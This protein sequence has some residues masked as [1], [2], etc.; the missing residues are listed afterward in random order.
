MKEFRIGHFLGLQLSVKPSAVVGTVLLLTLLVAVAYAILDQL[1]ATAVLGGATCVAVHWISDLVHQL[2]HAWTARRTGHPMVGVRFYQLWSMS[3]Y[4][5][6]EG[7]LPANVHIRRALGGPVVSLGSSLL[8]G[9]VAWM[10]VPWDATPGWIAAFAFLDNLVFF[11]GGA[12]LPLPFTDGGTLL[13]WWARRST[14]GRSV[15]D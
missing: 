6:D 9:A 5:S 4:P 15:H 1:L 2:G 14:V 13:T 10:L 8:T 12:L 3:L 7:R 11:T